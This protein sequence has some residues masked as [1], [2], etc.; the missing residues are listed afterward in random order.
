M[1][2]SSKELMVIES[3]LSSALTDN[4]NVDKIVDISD[5]LIARVRIIFKNG[6][7]LSI[8]SCK[9]MDGAR[10]GFFEIAPFDK[11]AEF[12]QSL[13]DIE[14]QG[15]DILGYCDVERVKYYIQKIGEL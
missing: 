8:I 3:A 4:Q 6:H 11:H 12:D 13:F 14:D 2:D 1:D 7:Q 5:Q 9:L 10:N 15:D